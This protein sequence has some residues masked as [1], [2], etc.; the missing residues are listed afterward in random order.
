MRPVW[1]V[2]LIPRLA[3]AS[4]D[5]LRI[6]SSSLELARQRGQPNHDSTP[7][8]PD[9]RGRETSRFRR[10]PTA[11]GTLFSPNEILRTSERSTST[12]SA[13]LADAP[14]EFMG[15]AP[16][17]EVGGWGARPEVARRLAR[18]VRGVG[19]TG[20]RRSP[21]GDLRRYSYYERGR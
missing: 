6:T 11:T 18:A 5:F 17:D 10:A 8:R 2:D 3:L 21:A 1:L 9:E 16:D 15:D 20:R 19:K 7:P 4:E 13:P 12:G 14:A